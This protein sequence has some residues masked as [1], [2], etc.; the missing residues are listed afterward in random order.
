MSSSSAASKNIGGGADEVDEIIWKAC[1]GNLVR[2][3][4]V[5]TT[6][7]YFPQ[8]HLEQSPATFPAS[9]LPPQVTSL[10]CVPCRVIHVRYLAEHA[11][12]EV[13]ASITL[14]KVSPQLLG[15]QVRV[16][17]SEDNDNYNDVVSFAKVL[18]PSDANNGGGFSVPRFCADSIFP[19]LDFTA[20]PPVQN[21]R[22]RDVRGET[23]EFRHIYRGTPRRHLLTTGWSKFVNSKKLV[24][25]D[26]VVFMRRKSTGELFVGVR[27][28]VKLSAAV[29]GGLISGWGPQ[30]GYYGGNAGG[31]RKGRVAVEKV[32]E[33]AEK[34]ARGEVFEVAYY[35]RA[36]VE[37]FVVGVEVVER[38]LSVCW[39]SGLK[40]KMATETEDSSRLQWF[41]GTVASVVGPEKGS[42]WRMLEVTWDDHESLRNMNRV[43]PWQVELLPATS[44]IHTAFPPTKKVKYSPDSGLFT[45]D[46]DEEFPLPT[47]GFSSM[48][49]HLSSPYL[50]YNSFPAGMQ[51]ARQN[52]FFVS[53]SPNIVTD[54][55]HQIHPEYHVDS[56]L[57]KVETVSTDLNTQNSVQFT[58]G[59]KQQHCLTSK[60][61]ITSFQLFGKTIKPEQ[62][63]NNTDEITGTKND[64]CGAEGA[65]TTM[66]DSLVDPYNKLHN[67]LQRSSV[68]EAYVKGVSG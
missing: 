17:R 53:S 30:P 10:P 38:G 60:A 46:D 29:S 39:S 34:A 48:M 24:A 27:R 67:K 36:G 35:P 64:G 19:P 8:G 47:V 57:Q 54:G 44:P 62:P 14:Q 18:T 23:F 32:V 58:A 25:G 26:S 61:G 2:L 3:P 40:I 45:D 65:G 16:G 49:G 68:T 12:D 20:D 66:D 33:A 11:T 7:Y 51:G 21:I 37:E 42:V 28:V 43:S 13:F 22:V 52:H 5:N 4:A 31:G 63:L 15:E 6:A 41:Q 9:C 1:A 50:N 59:T 56:M 55:T